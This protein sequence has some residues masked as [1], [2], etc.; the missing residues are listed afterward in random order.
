MDC[1]IACSEK[2]A[3][4]GSGSSEATGPVRSLPRAMITLAVMVP[5]SFAI[6][7]PAAALDEGDLRPG[8]ALK[9]TLDQ[10]KNRPLLADDAEARRLFQAVSKLLS[11]TATQRVDANKL[12]SESDFIVPPIWRETR[13]RRMESVQ[14]L[15]NA[16]LDVVTDVPLVEF[17]KQ[18]EASRANISALEDQITS[19][20]EKRLSA[21]DDA[22]L[23]GILSDTTSSI[24][25]EIEELK[26]RITANEAEITKAKS[27]VQ[28]ALQRSGLMVTS[29]QIDLL[30]GSVVGGD[31]IK[32][33]AAYQAA[34]KIDERLSTLMDDAQGEIKTS[35]RYF[36]M[37]AALYAMLLHAQSHVIEKIDQVYLKRMGDILASIKK[38]RGN[39]RRL[40]RERNRDD[41]IRVLESN[42]KEQ[43]FSERVALFYRDYLRTQRDQLVRARAQTRRDLRIADNTFSTVEASFQLRALIDDAKSSFEAMQM[44]EAPGFDQVFKN[45]EL[46][47]E[48]ENLTEKLTPPSS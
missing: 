46:R 30:L 34:R 12:P 28:A 24:D 27:E 17:Q 33:V 44:L 14:E 43:A 19:L 25:E 2:I 13:E 32:M 16:A 10:D 5:L 38:A 9:K 26:K 18:M 3:G 48:F 45:E 42:L 47:R 40:L 35:R 37:H 8:A 22:L 4:A 41:Q 31:M 36:A 6:S 15:L 23:P 21:P 7:S 29:D 11:D 39:T 1:K 20:R